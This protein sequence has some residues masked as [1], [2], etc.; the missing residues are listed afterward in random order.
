MSEWELRQRAIG[1]T[2]ITLP[3]PR[4]LPSVEVIKEG[5]GNCKKNKRIDARGLIEQSS[6]GMITRMKG[7][8]E[9]LL[10]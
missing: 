1:S 2:N 3:V 6:T 5:V 8:N 7:L 4:S 9:Q 10:D